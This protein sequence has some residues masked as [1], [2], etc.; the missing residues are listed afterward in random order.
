MRDAYF[1]GFTLIELIVVIAIL[2]IIAT[3]AVTRFVDL[4]S[5]A[6]VSVINSIAGT[7]KTTATIV[8][9]KALTQGLSPVGANPGA[10]QANYVVTTNIGSAEVDW[11]NLC[12]ESVAELA[13]RLIMLDY[14]DLSVSAG[15]TSQQNNRY[16][17][18][19][20]DIPGFSAPTNQGCYVIYDSFGNPNCTVTPVTVDC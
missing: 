4:K 17:L 16:T 14:V 18:V 3:F 13:D 7:M 9:A 10:G 1:K 5:S 11:R 20:Y 2:G 12:P 8:R 19:G 6:R 15:L